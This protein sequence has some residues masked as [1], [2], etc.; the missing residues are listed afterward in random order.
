MHGTINAVTAAS[1]LAMEVWAG[2]A[3]REGLFHGTAGRLSSGPDGRGHRRKEQRRAFFHCGEYF[4]EKCLH[5]GLLVGRM[6][7]DCSPLRGTPMITATA[8]GGS[9]MVRSLTHAM[10]RSPMAAPG[11]RSADLEIAHCV[12]NLLCEPPSHITGMAGTRRRTRSVR[13]PGRIA[14]QRAETRPCPKGILVTS[15]ACS[16]PIRH[17]LC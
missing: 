11:W 2:A 15:C 5:C 3:A 16:V 4:A 17:P 14:G 6:Q 10:T 1:G 12:D 9:P 13:L 8:E 7:L